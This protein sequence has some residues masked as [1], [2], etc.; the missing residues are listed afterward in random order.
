MISA[1]YNG[2]LANDVA[3]VQA[4]CHTGNCTW[5]LTP[6]MGV[7]GGC[8]SSSYSR[9]DC[10]NGVCNYS[11]PSGSVAS[12]YDFDNPSRNKSEDLAGFQVVPGRGAAFNMS[13]DNRLY[14]MNVDLFG[15]SYWSFA[16]PHPPLANTECALWMCIQTYKTTINSTIQ[17]QEILST[18]DNV[19]IG[20]HNLNV[21]GIPFDGGSY[22]DFPEL[23]SETPSDKNNGF[24][25]NLWA[26][27]ALQQYIHKSMQGSVYWNA[28]Q[29]FSNDLI[30]GIWNG[31]TNPHTWI[32]NVALSMS[33]VVR[34]TNTSSRPEYNGT[35]LALTIRIRWEWLT[36]P[37]ILVVTS[38][39]FLTMVVTQTM[40]SP[41]Q[42]WK[43][44][45]L[46]LLL[47][48]VDQ[49]TRKLAY[50]HLEEHKGALKAVGDQR[51]QL[52]E[53]EGGIRRFQAF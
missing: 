6:S 25:V 1:L 45:P 19:N 15:A 28:S 20:Y 34:S 44:S 46:T 43:G 49:D 42:S 53:V 18:Y 35:A 51:V 37:A 47:F 39:V 32:N 26:Y 48:D 36:I 8:A 9:I 14:I 31:T 22:Y 50:G 38:I 41:V 4:T 40:Y 2:V 7:C 27:L 24:S 11:F 17:H 21:S 33:N 30:R 23:P 3:P 5:P 29:H 16:N 13:L 52:L 12:L 10:A